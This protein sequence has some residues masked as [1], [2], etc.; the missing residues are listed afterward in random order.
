MFDGFLFSAE[1][2]YTYRE[3]KRLLKLVMQELRREPSVK[4]L[5]IDAKAPGRSA[6]TGSRQSG[7]WDFIP[8]RD[9]PRNGLFTTFPHLTLSLDADRVEAAITI[10]N[11]VMPA[12]RRRVADLGADG[13]TKLNA[14][15][16][17]LARRIVRAGGS[18]QAYAVQR[19]YRSQRSVGIVDARVTFRLE[20]SL[21]RNGP[22]KQQLAWIQLFA[23]LLGKRGANIQFGYTVH[24]PLELTGMET[25]QSVRWIADSW[26]ALAPLLDVLRGAE[27]RPR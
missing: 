3:G 5:G 23:N 13:L 1:N 14:R 19:H 20:T 11:G 22:I 26:C 7:V 4:A 12:V 2:P 10:P 25:R 27:R 17:K 18:L 24:L 6:I 16:V 15:I 9:R 8:L 21:P